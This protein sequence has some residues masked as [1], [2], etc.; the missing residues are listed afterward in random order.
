M[1][2]VYLI[3]NR[4]YPLRLFATRFVIRSKMNILFIWTSERVTRSLRLFETRSVILVIRVRKLVPLQVS[5]FNLDSC[6]QTLV[7][8]G[9]RHL[10]IVIVIISQWQVVFGMGKCLEGPYKAYDSWN[11]IDRFFYF[12]RKARRISKSCFVYKDQSVS[13]NFELFKA[14]G[15]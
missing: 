3:C 15:L 1:L 6:E 14:N 7:I 8:I 9:M 12:V 5:N 13:L 10:V 4:L 11:R 2:K